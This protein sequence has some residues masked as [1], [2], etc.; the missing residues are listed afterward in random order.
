MSI[1]A[2]CPFCHK[3]QSAKNKRCKCG[4]DM[5][6]LKRSKKV[7]YW[8]T[9]RMPNGKQRRESVGY[10]IEEA[11]RERTVYLKCSLNPKQLSR[12]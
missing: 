7:K 3:R 12:S 1:L 8:I 6:K 10:S 11:R 4:E 2:E 9:Y 5:D